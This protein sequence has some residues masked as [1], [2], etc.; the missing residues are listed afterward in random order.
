VVIQYIIAKKRLI[1]SI[2]KSR[3]GGELDKRCKWY[4]N[5]HH[6]E[7][8]LDTILIRSIIFAVGVI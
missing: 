7:Y 3:A 8:N 1:P 4:I 2:A 5:T 6:R